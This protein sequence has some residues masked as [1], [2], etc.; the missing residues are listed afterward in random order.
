MDMHW[1]ATG[2]S[3]TNSNPT[4]EW[5]V[6]KEI[7]PTKMSRVLTNQSAPSPEKLPHWGMAIFFD[8]GG[9][10][11]SNGQTGWWIAEE[12]SF[13][14]N[15]LLWCP[16]ALAEIELWSGMES[17]KLSL[18]FILQKVDFGS[19]IKRLEH[20]LQTILKYVFE[21]CSS[22]KPGI[23]VFFWI[24]NRP[25]RNLHVDPLNPSFPR[26]SFSFAGDGMAMAWLHELVWSGPSRATQRS[27]TGPFQG[28]RV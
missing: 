7:K 19:L 15:C 1:S 6:V 14:E 5:E 23:L 3:T 8:D 9:V 24:S 10:G 27:C 12:E 22:Q 20:V 4:V 11:R 28:S 13:G 16:G 2:W 17:L 26:P 21:S 18:S 25:D